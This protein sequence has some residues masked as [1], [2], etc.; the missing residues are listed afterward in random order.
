MTSRSQDDWRL[1]GQES[2]LRGAALIWKR[3]RARSEAWD[4]DH[5][6]FCWAKFMDPDLSEAY[7]QWVAEQPDTLVEG[8]TTIADYEHGLDY[9]WICKRC[10]DDFAERFQWRVLPTRD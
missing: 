8:Y 1:R 4:H 9:H 5:C 6:V 7:R 3:Y 10:F 2:Y